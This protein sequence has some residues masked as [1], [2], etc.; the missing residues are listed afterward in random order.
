MERFQNVSDANWW[1]DALR[2]VTSKLYL[3]PLTLVAWIMLGLHTFFLL[4]NV[5]TFEF[6]KGPRHID[7]LQG[8]EDMDFPFSQG[9]VGNIRLCCISDTLCNSTKLCLGHRQENHPRWKPVLW[10]KP[11]KI[12]RDS[13]DWWNHPWQNKYWSCC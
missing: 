8:T 7:Y 10:Q 1:F 6:T 11:G 4:C 5:T 3:Y 9:C 12:I 13:P 2:V